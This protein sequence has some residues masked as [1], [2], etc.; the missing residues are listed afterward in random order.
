MT[1]IGCWADW[2][3]REK[4][5]VCEENLTYLRYSLNRFCE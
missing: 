5:L 2:R 1:L 3:V 4:S